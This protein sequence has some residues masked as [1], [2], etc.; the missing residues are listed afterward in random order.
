MTQTKL[1]KFIDQITQN[2]IS[3]IRNNPIIGNIFK[4]KK[5]LFP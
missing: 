1:T 2:N 5:R 3:K 4:Q